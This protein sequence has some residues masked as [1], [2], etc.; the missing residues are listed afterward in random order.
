MDGRWN[1][2]G[3]FW[4]YLDQMK[5]GDEIVP[6]RQFRFQ[7]S[8]SPSQSVSDI[9]LEGVVGEEID[10]ENERPGEGASFLFGAT[11]RAGDHLAFRLDGERRWLDDRPDSSGPNQRLFTAGVGRIKA[12]WTFSARSFV[13]LIGQWDRLTRDPALYEY[14]VPE[15]EGGFAGS[16]LFSYKLN[17]QSVLFVGYGDNRALDPEGEM[18]KAGRE[19]FLK[20]S[21]AF[22]R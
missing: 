22:Q 13:R 7:M 17:W 2:F 19:L 5:A 15:E 20:I 18:Q 4:L 11:L 3:R 21:Y 9:G 8:A 12:I 10:I 1:S 14:P 6:R 16:A